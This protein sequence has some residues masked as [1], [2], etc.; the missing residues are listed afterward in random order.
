LIQYCLAVDRGN[1][2][3]AYLYEPA[4][5]AVLRMIKQVIDS[6]HQAGI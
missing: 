2:K 6:A 3:V 1:E 5:P 4:H